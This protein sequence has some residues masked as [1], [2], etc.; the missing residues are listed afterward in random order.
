MN[1][2][3]VAHN[4]L[5]LEQAMQYYKSV[6]VPAKLEEATKEAPYVALLLRFDDVGSK[7][8]SIVLEISFIPGMEAAEKEGV[9]LMQSFAVLANETDVNRELELQRTICEINTTL[10]IG[11]FGLFDN[12]GECYYKYNAIVD[13]QW[14]T[15]DAALKRLDRQN[16][17]IVHLLNQY[18][19][20]L[21]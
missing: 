16:G 11:A 8:A 6:E 1:N 5:L 15:G 10:P 4:R 3:Q 7:N 2:K 17:L 21:T 18:A 19:D 9:Y 14:L 20:V 12:G 13:E